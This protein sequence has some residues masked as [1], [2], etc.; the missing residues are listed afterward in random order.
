M[1]AHFAEHQIGTLS[2]SHPLHQPFKLNVDASDVE[3]GAVLLQ[4]HS[5]GLQPGEFLLKEM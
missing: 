5:N 1:S 2:I 3:A 4:K